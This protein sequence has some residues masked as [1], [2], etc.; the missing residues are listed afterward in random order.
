MVGKGIAEGG[1]KNA[2][3]GKGGVELAIEGTGLGLVI[4]GKELELREGCKGPC[5]GLGIGDIAT[6]V[7]VGTQSMKVG[8]YTSACI[9]T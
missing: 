1:G 4:E 6:G 5:K 3:G 7:I 8:W 9:G 2:E